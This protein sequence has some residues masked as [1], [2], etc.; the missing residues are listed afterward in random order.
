MSVDDNF[1][2]DEISSFLRTRW[3]GTEGRLLFFREIGSTNDEA[4]SQAGKG[5]EE[6]LVVIADL[7]NSGKG[8]RG[9][10]WKGEAGLNTAMSY[11]L[12]PDFDPDLASAITLI[13]ALSCRK[14]IRN[15]TGLETLIKWPNDIVSKG[16][17]L[18]G[19]LTEMS[20]ENGRIGYVVVGTGININQSVF[21]EEI[22][23]TASSLFLETGE[24]VS[25][26]GIT[27]ECANCFEEY[28]ELFKSTGS[29]KDMQDEYNAVCV[30][31]GRRVKV[32]DPLKSFEGE[33]LGINERGSLL[34]RTD[35]G[36]V[37]EVY[38]GEVSVRGVYG[39][40]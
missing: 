6:G 27:A 29:L 35:D 21:P 4:V 11:L 19:I 30:N 2:V 32:L 40:T 28:Y 1:G 16:K 10:V 22:S 36:R 5:A 18:V 31:N 26:S 12:R 3:L 33:A 15:V 37:R 13:M 23:E 7:Q 34:V 38:A 20:P 39:Y 25:R 8:R 14:A 24:K 9:R 17:K